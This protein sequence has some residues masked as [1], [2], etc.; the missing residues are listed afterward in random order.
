ML[1]E[2]ESE[3][4]SSVRKT[5]ATAVKVSSATSTFLAALFLLLL[6]DLSFIRSHHMFQLSAVCKFLELTIKVLSQLSSSENIEIQLLFCS[7]RYYS[8][9]KSINLLKTEFSKYLTDE[10][11]YLKS[12][13]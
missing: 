4:D 11:K 7:R 9:F 10:Q 13:H 1:E 8:I 2:W 12:A 5:W 6:L 3:L